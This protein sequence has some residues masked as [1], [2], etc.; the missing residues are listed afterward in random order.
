MKL[1]VDLWLYILAL[2][3]LE[4]AVACTLVSREFRVL[5]EEKT[6]WLHLLETIRKYQPLPCPDDEKIEE[7]DVSGLKHLALHTIRRERNW[8]SEVDVATIKKVETFEL[9]AGHSIIHSIPGTPY[10]VVHSEHDGTVTWW[11]L[12][13]RLKGDIVYVGRSVFHVSLALCHK[14]AHSFALLVTDEFA[15]DYF[16]RPL[17]LV[18]LTFQRAPNSNPRMDISFK[19]SLQTWFTYGQLFLNAHIVGFL[20]VFDTETLDIIAYNLTSGAC[21]VIHTDKLYD[22]KMGTYIDHALYIVRDRSKTSSNVHICPAHLLPYFDSEEKET[23]V[24]DPLHWDDHGIRFW[25]H[26][27][28]T[29]SGLETWFEALG[30]VATPP[31]RGAALCTIHHINIDDEPLPTAINI[32]LWTYRERT[33]GGISPSRRLYPVYRLNLAGWLSY[34]VSTSR[35]YHLIDCSDVSILLMV[36]FHGRRS[37]R[38]VRYDPSKDCSS[39]HQLA[40]PPSLDL[41]TVTGIA[42]DDHRATVVLIDR[43]GAFIHMSSSSRRLSFGAVLTRTPYMGGMLANAGPLRSKAPNAEISFEN[44]YTW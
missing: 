11:N 7:R 19:R 29:F 15:A 31:V 2:V 37:L 34:V 43:V 41:T 30:A 20:R 1:S 4:D 42:L 14:D 39:I 36:E 21:R 12:V 16:N 13:D 38:L 3:P 6:F 44:H 40:S 17:I 23:H 26:M 18:V 35:H 10:L 25:G 9:G 33:N 24:A 5:A 22:R 32:R 27:D 8:S 28:S